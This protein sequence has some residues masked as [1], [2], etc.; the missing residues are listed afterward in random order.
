MSGMS[1]ALTA[2]GLLTGLVLLNQIPRLNLISS[3]ILATVLF[4]M[5]W[6]VIFRQAGAWAQ[7]VRVYRRNE[8]PRKLNEAG[9][10]IAI[11]FFSEAVRISG[12]GQLLLKY[13]I[14]IIETTGLIGIALSIPLL[15]TVLSMVGINNFVGI[16]F[17]GTILSPASAGIDPVFLCMLYVLGGAISIIPSPFSIISII[18]GNLLKTSSYWVA[19][20]NIGYSFLYLVLGAILLTVCFT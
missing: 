9:L 1:L 7:S 16:T 20:L 3:L 18:T 14:A 19:R 4:P 6:S 8:F 17:I 5:I 2:V 10:F 11:G 15:I 13:F 12:V